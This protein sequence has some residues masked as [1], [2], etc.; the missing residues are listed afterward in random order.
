[1]LI[2]HRRF[3][4]TLVLLAATSSL[5][6]AGLVVGC[7]NTATADP[8]VPHPNTKPCKVALFDHYRFADFI[9]KSFTY[10]SPACAGPWA[11]VILIADFSVTAG[12]QFDRTANIWIGPTNIYFGTT[13]EPSHNVARH[14]QIESDLTDYSSIFTTSQAGTV[15]LGNVVDGTYTGNLY[16]SATLLFYPVPPKQ[17]A[18][19]T[20]DQVIG[21][22]AG[23][24]GGTV[25]LGD[26]SS[27]LEQTLT[28]TT[29]IE[30]VY[31]DVFAQSQHDDEFWYTCVP[32]GVGCN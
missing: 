16:G 12:R 7:P 10:N 30:R 9:P 23:A 3:V 31:F 28:L 29:N 8:P 27:L 25:G 4:A 2:S 19:V 22:F 13:S 1:V 20:A 5:A 15:D 6:F 24:T 32:N 14:W 18:P 17:T 11:K 26:S 21:F